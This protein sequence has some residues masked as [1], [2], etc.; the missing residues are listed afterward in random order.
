MPG[1]LR[2]AA[3]LMVAGLGTAWLAQLISPSPTAPLFDGVFVE[4]PYL[5]VEPPP[6]AGGNPLSVEVTNSVVDGAVPLLAAATAEVPPQAQIIA[7]ADAF[8]ISADSSSITVSITPSAPRDPGLVGNVYTF[9]VTDQEGSPLAIRPGALVTI[10]LR[11]PEQ[12][13]VAQVARFDGDE[14]VTL[15]TQHGG[16]PDL[17][18]ANIEQLGDYGVLLSA[19]ASPSAGASGSPAP[20]AGVSTPSPDSGMPTWVIVLLAVAAVG[21]G[22]AWGLFSDG[23]QR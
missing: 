7:Q 14:W 15:P 11:A 12:N 17:F 23:D 9:S 22:L 1:R 2:L 18:A 4:D 8:E 19:A 6:S 3:A 13:L 21:A 10:V 5:F 20:S 16:L